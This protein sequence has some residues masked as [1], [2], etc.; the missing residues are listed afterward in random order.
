MTRFLAVLA[1]W[2]LI[3]LAQP[4]VLRPDGFGH[5]AFFALGPWA[6]AVRRPGRRAFVSEWAAHSLGLAGVFAWMVQFMP[7]ILPPMS[8]IPALHLC[9]AGVLLRRCALWPMALLAPAAW[10]AAEV[11]R[12]S[13]PVPLSFG[14]FRLGMLMHDTEWLVGSAAYF[15]TWGLTWA[16]A[17]LGGLAADVATSL[18]RR[19]GEPSRLALP[20]VFGVLPLAVL[21]ALD[22]AAGSPDVEDGP[23]VI[24]VQPGISQELKAARQDLFQDLYVPQVTATLKAMYET[25]PTDRKGDSAQPDLVLWGE[26]FLPG[27]L[28]SAEVIEAYRAGARP[29]PWARPVERL[30]DL[31]FQDRLAR[32]LAGALFGSSEMK[33]RDPSLWRRTFGAENGPEWGY[34]VER[35]E[36]LIPPGTS[37]LSGAEAWTVREEESGPVLKSVNGVALWSADGEIGPVASKVH[38]VPGGESAEPLKHL[39]FILDAIKKVASAVPDFVGADEASVLTLRTRSGAA[40]RLGVAICFDNAFD[41]PFTGPLA[42]GP[43][44]FFV[45]ASN[46]AWYGDS[47]LMDHM[48]AFSRVLAAATQRSIVRATNSGISSLVGPDGVVRE[49]L[50]DGKKRKMISGVLRAT[51]PVPTRRSGGAEEARPTLFVRTEALQRPIWG[52][53]G[54]LVV[55]LGVFA[56]RR[57]KSSA[58]A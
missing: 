50:V 25:R 3:G 15:G 46:E 17:A 35:S 38:A 12:W 34:R 36:R 22:V 57:R 2:A 27:K 54:A 42:K 20:A 51:V 37:F 21:I 53:F 24:I 4:G 14:W 28:A 7:A 33:R 8:I 19:E 5:L 48:L 32:D 49:V 26:T 13:L 23:D 47:P 16:L 9:V 41:D 40:Y 31:L 10:M 29:A 39:P 56:G 44:D 43:V 6:Y 1:T 45:V 52:S 58:E 30:A 11:I 55:L 18:R